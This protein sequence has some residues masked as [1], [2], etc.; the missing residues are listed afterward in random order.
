[1]NVDPAKINPLGGAVALGHAIG[2]SGCRIIV[3]LAHALKPG[4]YGAA[5]ICNGGGAASAMV[6]QRL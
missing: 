3:T 1:M 6:I 5:G 2:N 4:E